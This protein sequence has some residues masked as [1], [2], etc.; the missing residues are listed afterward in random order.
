MTTTPKVII[1]TDLD[2]TLLDGETHGFEAARPALRSLTQKGIPLIPVSSKT[3]AEIERIREALGNHHPFV[4]ENGG[5]I[6]IPKTYFSFPFPYQKESD[7][8]L[9]LELGVPYAQVLKT[10][11]SI[12]EETGVSLKGFSDFTAEELTFSLRFTLEEAVLAKEREYDEPFLIQTDRDQIETIK[13]KIEEKG[14]FYSWGG[15]FHHLH[16]R[17]DKGKAVQ[18][19]KELYENEFFSVQAV[20]IGDS[21][22]DAPMFAAVDHPILL[23]GGQDVLSYL[24]LDNLTTYPGTG[25]RTWN[26]AVLGLLNGLKTE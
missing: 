4:S 24:S 15:R 21:L 26:K 17:N 18:I 22:N 2:G 13:R 8:Y 1:F 19:L 6:F 10:F 7:E 11:R 25:P 3:R 5:A 12:Q 14:M 9:I 23:V 16:G 20:A